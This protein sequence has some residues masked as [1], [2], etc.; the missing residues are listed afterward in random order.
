MIRNGKILSLS[1]WLHSTWRLGELSQI[2]LKMV[3]KGVLLLM[4]LPLSY[5]LYNSR[6]VVTQVK[7][8]NNLCVRLNSSAKITIIC[9]LLA[10]KSFGFRSFF[11]CFNSHF[12]Y[13]NVSDTSLLVHSREQPG[14]VLQPNYDPRD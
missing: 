14:L 6:A 9:K 3:K 13:V 8:Q 5:D 11:P 12:N 2:Q 7:C 4:E 10:C 1:Q